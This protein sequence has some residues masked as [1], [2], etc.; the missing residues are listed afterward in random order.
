[1]RATD[2]REP[3]RLLLQIKAEAGILEESKIDLTNVLIHIILTHR[4]L[5]LEEYLESSLVH[6]FFTEEEKISDS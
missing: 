6:L 2:L 1:M 4:N 3:S 5:S